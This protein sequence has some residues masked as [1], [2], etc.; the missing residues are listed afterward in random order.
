MYVLIYIC[1]LLYCRAGTDS[2]SI[3]F[4]SIWPEHDLKE[5]GLYPPRVLLSVL[6]VA[7]YPL[8]SLYC[9]MVNEFPSSQSQAPEQMANAYGL[10]PQFLTLPGYPSWRE[11]RAS[12]WPLIA[13]VP[14]QR[15]RFVGYGGILNS[16]STCSLA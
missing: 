14:V 15:D 2:Y 6:A 11:F 8:H 13:C 1:V 7:Y 12:V 16:C 4:P 10:I 5:P 9:F 3:S